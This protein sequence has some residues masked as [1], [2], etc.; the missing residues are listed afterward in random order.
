MIAKGCRLNKRVK[1]SAKLTLQ[2]IVN[3]LPIIIGML[4]LTSLAVTILPRAISAGL[5]GGRAFFDVLLGALIGSVAVGQPLAS[6]ILGGELLDG[7]VSL[8]AVTALIVSWVTV[9]VVQ[10]P[11]EA[12]LLGRRFAIVR[13]LTCVVFAIGVSYFTVY[14]LRLIG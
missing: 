1:Q 6:Y 14:T 9:G 11:A 10:L 4:L 2:T 13:N 12:L 8:L 3:L 5:F 7:G